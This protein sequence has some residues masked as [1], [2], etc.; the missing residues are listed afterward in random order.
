MADPAEPPDAE[1]PASA[2]DQHTPVH[3]AL[4]GRFGKRLPSRSLPER[5]QQEMENSPLVTHSCLLSAITLLTSCKAR[6]AR[7]QDAPPGRRRGQQLGRCGR[8]SPSVG[9]TPGSDT[10]TGGAWRCAPTG[11][12][13]LVALLAGG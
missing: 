2:D 9:R 10:R 12:P 7:R 8:S 5:W 13:L 11:P 6:A 4:P 1:S 3:P